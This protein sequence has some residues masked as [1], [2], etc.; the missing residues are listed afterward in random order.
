MRIGVISDTHLDGYREGLKR[1]VD[2]C[3]PD[4]D[5]ILH[6]GDMVDI[7]VL[8][9][10]SGREVKAVS[11][12]MDNPS[13]RSIMPEKLEF[14]IG[15]FRVGLI[16]GWG[17]PSGIRQ[18]LRRE[19]ADI[20][21]IVYGHTHEAF[22]ACSEG[23]LFFNPGSAAL[24]SSKKTVGILEINSGISGQIIEIQDY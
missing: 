1:V 10:F 20:D 2:D 22:N 6:A 14:T 15:G 17:N 9:V 18:K 16:H 21:C 11:G 23:V 19:F 24:F 3:F 12:N 4:V 13:V 5:L 8:N 7:G